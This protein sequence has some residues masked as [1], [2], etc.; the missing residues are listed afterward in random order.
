MTVLRGLREALVL[1][2]IAVVVVAATAAVW[3]ALAGGE[4][5]SVSVSPRSSPEGCWGSPVT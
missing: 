4:F 1:F 2:V 3:V 5:T